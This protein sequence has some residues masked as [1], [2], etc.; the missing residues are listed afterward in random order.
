MHGL[1]DARVLSLLETLVHRIDFSLVTHMG[2][3]LLHYASDCGIPVLRLLLSTNK[4]DPNATNTLGQTASSLAVL[5]L[6]RS[7]PQ[8]G[9]N[10]QVDPK[11]DNL[12]QDALQFGFDKLRS[13]VFCFI[14]F[15]DLALSSICVL[16][17]VSTSIDR[18]ERLT[19]TSLVPTKACVRY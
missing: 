8:F 19:L 17:I 13:V 4:L 9:N 6:L 18:K 7:G 2:N 12:F 1:T 14:F 16:L 10:A 5:R 11:A 15:S 3:T